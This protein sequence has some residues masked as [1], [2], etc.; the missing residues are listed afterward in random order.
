MDNLTFQVKLKDKEISNLREDKKKADRSVSGL[1]MQVNDVEHQ[2][3][4]KNSAINSLKEQIKFYKLQC[5]ETD[6]QRK[7]IQRLKKHIDTM[8]QYVVS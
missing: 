8:T 3:N 4:S 6:N 7:E 1:R 2:L 5:E